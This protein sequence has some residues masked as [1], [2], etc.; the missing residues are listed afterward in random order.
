MDSISTQRTQVHPKLRSVP[1]VSPF[2]MKQEV[3]SLPRK[4]LFDLYQE[5]YTVVDIPTQTD[6]VLKYVSMQLVRSGVVFSEDELKEKVVKYQRDNKETLINNYGDLLKCMVH[7]GMKDD[8]PSAFDVHVSELENNQRL[9]NGF[10][11]N[12]LALLLDCEIVVFFP[13]QN[14]ELGIYR[15][16]RNGKKLR[17]Q[18]AIVFNGNRFP[19]HVFS[20]CLVH[21]KDRFDNPYAVMNFDS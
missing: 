3:L 16:N 14:E 5:G 11:I 7:V 8:L 19:Y 4:F 6:P 12:C 17:R 13:N 18:I 21:K 10:D 15:Y 9:A 20:T 1:P 2:H